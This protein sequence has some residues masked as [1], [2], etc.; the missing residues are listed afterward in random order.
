[1]RLAGEQA[2]LAKQPGQRKRSHSAAS[3]GQKLPPI[4][5]GF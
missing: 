1:L 2:I 4:G 5:D 3:A